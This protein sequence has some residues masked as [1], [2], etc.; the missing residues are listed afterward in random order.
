MKKSQSNL[1]SVVRILAT[2]AVFNVFVSC[3]KDQPPQSAPPQTHSDG[4]IVLGKKINDPYSISNMR[5][6]YANI[7]G[8]S[9]KSELAP[10]RIYMRFLPKNEEEWDLLKSDKTL[11]LYDFPLDY[12]IA[13]HGNYYHDPS[14]PKDAITWQYV[15]VPVDYKIPNIHHEILYEVFIPEYEDQSLLK[16]SEQEFYDKLEEESFRLTGNLPEPKEGTQLKGLLP[17]KWTPKGRIM[18]YDDTFG[19]IPLQGANVHGR[20]ST[21]TESTLTDANGYFTLPQFRYEVNYCIKYQRDDFDIRSGTVGQAWYD[22]PKQKGDW[23]LTIS[24]GVHKFYATILRA[25]NH[26]FYGNVSGLKRPSIQG[27]NMKIAAM[28]EDNDEINGRYSAPLRILGIFNEVKIFNPNRNSQGTYGTTIHE[29]AHAAHWDMDHSKFNDIETKVVESWA[30]GMQWYLTR[31]I[32]PNYVP[33]YS[34]DYTG[35][36]S[37]MVSSYGYT[38]NQLET[39]IKGQTTW[40][41]WRDNIIN[42]YNNGNEN[43]L[44]ALFSRVW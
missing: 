42:L 32:Y 20:W 28:D 12:E 40:N 13:V 11:L 26:Y 16:S 17:D 8:T 41:G 9:L 4:A 15:V 6:A 34:G 39:A 30:R 31:M 22:G 2:L 19:T 27:S 35:V 18:V 21:H 10:N 23:N 14:L 33:S 43:Q 3:E 44:P 1:R 29:L 7:A 24:G 38:M 25:A 5:A 37:V 36:V